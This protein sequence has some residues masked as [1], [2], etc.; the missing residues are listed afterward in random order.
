MRSASSSR[1]VS[2]PLVWCAKSETRWRMMRTKQ[3]M[4]LTSESIAKHLSSLSA[5]G[6][7][8]QTT[9]AYGS[10][11]REFLRQTG[12]TSIPMEEFEDLAMEWLNLHRTTLSAKTTG[13]RR[14][15]LRSYAKWAGYPELLEDY[16]DPTPARPNPHPLPEGL[17]GVKRMIAV[18]TD[19][20]HRALVAFGGLVGCRVAEA[21]S[22]RPV[23]FNL[24]DMTLTIHGKGD[25]QRIV[26]LSTEAWSILESCVMQCVSHRGIR[27]TVIP[28]KDRYAR[29]VITRLG[30]QAGLRRPVSSHDLRMTFATAVYEKQPNLRTVQELLGHASSQ[31]TEGYTFVSL[32]N[33]R[34]AVEL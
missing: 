19:P 26:P 8:L 15:S 9:R 20:S 3:V 31:T 10:D 33:M 32:D 7:S 21:L 2:T 12:M 30:K 18:A 13:R 14:S 29:E 23:D 6:R 24:A 25:K 27:A 28:Y 34:K 16:V 22:V 5:R 11:L 4:T 1:S 17:D